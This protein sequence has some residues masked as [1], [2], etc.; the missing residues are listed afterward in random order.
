M[1]ER[2]DCTARHELSALEPRCLKLVGGERA[3]SLQVAE[4]G[5]NLLMRESASLFNHR[6]STGVSERWLNRATVFS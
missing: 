5:R 2:V 4:K 1:P 3:S 6:L